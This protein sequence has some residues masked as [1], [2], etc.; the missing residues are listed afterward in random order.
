M[1]ATKEQIKEYYTAALERCLEAFSSLDEKE[2]A[3]KASDHWTAKEHLAHIVAALEEE[4]LPLTRQMLA[5]EPARLPGFGKRTD[6]REFQA[7][8]MA[9]VRDLPTSEVLARVK[10]AVEEHS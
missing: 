10:A 8:T 3:K 4:T 6:E 5:G 9:A 1:K 7:A 2:W